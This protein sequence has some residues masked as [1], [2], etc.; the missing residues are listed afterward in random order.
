MQL[1][2]G[3]VKPYLVFHLQKSL[4]KCQAP[5]PGVCLAVSHV[6]NSVKP[7]KA[8]SHF[9]ILITLFCN[10]QMLAG[11]ALKCC[12]SQMGL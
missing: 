12:K 11:T 6:Q 7:P 9:D 2:N 1:L 3:V 4:I 5:I 10:L 8:Q